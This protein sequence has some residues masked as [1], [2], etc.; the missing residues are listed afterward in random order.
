VDCC[1]S[2]R[3]DTQKKTIHAREQDRPDVKKRRLA[4]LRRQ[5][6]LRVTR[7]VFVDESGFRLGSPPNY[8]W[9]P[10]GDKSPGKA[11]HGAWRTITM[12][13][14]IALNGW[15]GFL[16]VNAATDREVFKAYV[17]QLLVPNLRRGIVV[18]DNL[19]VHKDAASIAA[20]RDAGADVLF[21]PP[22]SPDFNPIE[23]AWA[24]LKEILRRASTL[25]REAF[26]NAVAAAMEQISTADIRAWTE[27]AGY[28]VGSN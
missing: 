22:Y 13:G 4:F 27:H 23:K 25:T 3:L 14:A 16:T 2:L 24:K 19:A 11:T 5:L 9:A 1:P 20:I 10:I 17:Q 28:A 7:L 21:L 15:R 18:M 26:D 6:A 8:G 12:I